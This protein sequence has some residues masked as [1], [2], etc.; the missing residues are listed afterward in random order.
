[1][2]FSPCS[3]E[4]SYLVHVGDY[5]IKGPS[6]FI[7]L[8]SEFLFENSHVIAAGGEIN[9]QWNDALKERPQ[10]GQ[11]VWT[12][13]WIKKLRIYVYNLMQYERNNIYWCASS[14][15]YYVAGDKTD[16]HVDYWAPIVTPPTP[17]HEG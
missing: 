5:I 15:L 11:K 3:S 1:M 14:S 12:A 17:P 16:Q 4:N 7:S 10:E 9:M 8:Q 6:G 2:Y 13:T